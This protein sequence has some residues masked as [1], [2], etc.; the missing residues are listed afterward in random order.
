MATKAPKTPPAPEPE[1]VE[2]IT[3]ESLEASA[4][5]IGS[6][7][8]A[9]DEAELG[10]EPAAYRWHL[11]RAIYRG[12]GGLKRD[13]ETCT[14][15]P[16]GVGALTADGI[17]DDW[18]PGTYLAQLRAAP[19]A[20][21]SGAVRKTRIFHVAA[22]RVSGTPNQAAAVPGGDLVAVLRQLAEQQQR[23]FEHLAQLLSARPPAA[24]VDP[25]AMLDLAMRMADR[26]TPPRDKDGGF[27]TVAKW[28]DLADRFRSGEKGVYDLVSKGIDT[29][30]PLVDVTVERLGGQAPARGNGAEAAPAAAAAGNGQRKPVEAPPMLQLAN[31]LQRQ[32]RYLTG[33]AAQKS[34]A[35]L[36]AE[37]VLDNM[38]EG[39]TEE[40][41]L[42][43]L[44][45]PGALDRVFSMLSNDDRVAAQAQRA[46][47]EEL[48]REMIDFLEGLKESGA[49]ETAQG[50]TAGTKGDTPAA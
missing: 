5:E 45:T 49:G 9:A 39:V 31:Y 15:Y 36:Y 4:I 8:F 42:G 3:E 32:V 17:R 30:A 28:F 1:R 13:W 2:P 21:R 23:S 6:P 50:D 26:M 35:Q 41:I 12:P 33:K 25:A 46:W 47:F 16:A 27:D 19:G 11:S 34:S 14:S 18:G 37:V 44:K 24:S 43:A 22:P 20:G 29:L 7:D 48:V 38:P 40:Q 10:E